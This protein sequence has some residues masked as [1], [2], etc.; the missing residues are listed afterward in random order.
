MKKI[1]KEPDLETDLMRAV[2]DG[3]VGEVLA[4]LEKGILA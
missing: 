2:V 1:K 3:N 4:C